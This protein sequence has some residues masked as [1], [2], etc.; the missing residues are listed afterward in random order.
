[1]NIFKKLKLRYNGYVDFQNHIH[2][3]ERSYVSVTAYPP[4]FLWVFFRI[5]YKF[6]QREWKWLIGTF[7]A[8]L[9]AFTAI[10]VFIVML[11]EYIRKTNP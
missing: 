5:I 9:G 10:G 3:P 6:S 11:L 2:D 8:I 1:M 7:I 4:S